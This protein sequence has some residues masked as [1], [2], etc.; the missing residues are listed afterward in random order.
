MKKIIFVILL[1]FFSASSFSQGM[2][3]F[4]LG[5]GYTTSYHSYITPAFEGY[6]LWKLTPHI[7]AG[8]SLFLQR[9]SFLYDMKVDPAHVN[10]Y[11]IISIRQKSSYLFFSPKIDFGIGYRKYVHI[12]LSGGIGVIMAGKQ[13]SNEYA[14]L[15]A[16]AGGNI[17]AD[18]SA[19]N[20]S[21]NIPRVIYRAGLG[22]SERI[23]TYGFFNVMLSLE[24]SYL[25]ANLNNT[26]PNFYTNYLSFT[27]GLMHKYPQVIKEYY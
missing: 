8:G 6:Y 23:P 5:L 19:V 11:D 17:G 15:L 1:S 4:G 14:P 20:T 13:W 9:Y 10:Y 2:Y 18:T 12:S 21:Y 7:Y 26:S 22:V 27:V 16:T 24:F 25:P 3:G